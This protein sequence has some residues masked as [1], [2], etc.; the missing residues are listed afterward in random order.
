MAAPA[1]ALG[2]WSGLALLLSVAVAAYLGATTER[3]FRK[4]TYVIVGYCAA[5]GVL[6][7]TNAIVPIDVPKYPPLPEPYSTLGI[8]IV[9]LTFYLKVKRTNS[10]GPFALIVLALG[11]ITSAVLALSN[12]TL[13]STIAWYVAAAA[14]IVAVL[15]PSIS[16]LASRNKE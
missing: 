7:W 4:L 12:V 16:G 15:G 5:I 11:C 13:M 8:G 9:V 2:T 14:F 1:V 10:K 3:N 6:Y